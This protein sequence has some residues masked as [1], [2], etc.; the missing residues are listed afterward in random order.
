MLQDGFNRFSGAFCPA[1]IAFE[2][3]S[4]HAGSLYFFERLFSFIGG[5]AK[6]ECDVRP[7]PGHGKRDGFTQTAGRPRDKNRFVFQVC[8]AGIVN[9]GLGLRL[10]NRRGALLSGGETSS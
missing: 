10:R 9:G 7:G 4:L 8:H 6:G 3:K 1:Q 2:S 5:R